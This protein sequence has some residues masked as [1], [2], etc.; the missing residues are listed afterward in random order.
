MAIPVLPRPVRLA[1]Q[2][3]ADK[4]VALGT[5][6]AFYA[7]ALAATPKVLA[8]YW[9]H[10]L[11]LTGEISFGS[12]ALLAG[13]GT[14]GVIFAMSFVSGT[15]VGL[16]GF[17]GLDLVGLSPMAGVMSAVANT[18]E[19]APA[20]A[21]IALAAKVGTGFTAQL[22][23]MRISDEVDALESM[24]IPSIPFLVTTRMIAAF[25]AVV[26]LYLVGLFAS[27]VATGITVVNINGQSQG[28][29]DYYFTLF[30]PPQDV[31][32]SLLKALFFAGIVTLVHCYHGYFARGG[33]E[34]VGRAA[35]RALRTSIVLIM[36]ADVLLT[37]LLWGV[38]QTLP[39]M[40]PK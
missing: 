24:S 17:R 13:G 25:A 27:Y 22:G 23:A 16:E 2:A 5:Q 37:M 38:H 7:S 28:T 9:R 8:R 31:L 20:V 3:S 11:R 30:L 34:G 35:G 39:G 26:P 18:R 1:G 32:F 21:S 12:G 19:L 40:A 6:F 15:Q 10:V 33:P 29:Y 4:L 36:F 14:V